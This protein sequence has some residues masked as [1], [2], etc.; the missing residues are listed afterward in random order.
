MSKKWKT[1]LANLF[2]QGFVLLN[3]KFQKA[4]SFDSARDFKSIVIF[5]TTALGDLMFNTPAIRAIRQRYPEA[6]ITLVSSEKNKV[7]VSD[8]P[9]FD[10]II[11]WDEKVKDILPLVSAMKEN[12]PELAIIL[13]SKAPYDIVSSVMAGCKYIIKDVYG[14]RKTGME[15]WLVNP[16]VN[17]DGHLIQRKLNLLSMLGCATDNTDMFIPTRFSPI[18]KKPNTISIGFQMGASEK[19][20]CWPISRFVELA[21]Q[22]AMLGTEYEIVLIGSNKEK[23][24]EDIFLRSIPEHLK[25]RVVSHIGKTD[26][27]MLLAIIK[28]LDILVTG[29]TGPLHLAVA[30]KTKTVSL[31][32]TANPKHTGPYQDHQLHEV[33]HVPL[34]NQNALNLEQPLSAISVDQVLRNIKKLLA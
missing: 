34:N 10:K 12:K 19:I 14:N 2:L 20:R 23:E 15:Q 22:I 28:N 31:F 4:E 6:C 29:D 11:Y 13:H 25:S 17:F 26:L 30:L 3:K 18:D 1:T 16:T 21:Q 24:H 32:V 27:K 5:S 33:L 7:L 8:S 9:C